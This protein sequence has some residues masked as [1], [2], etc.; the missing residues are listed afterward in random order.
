ML[1]TEAGAYALPGDIPVEAAGIAAIVP[2]TVASA[3]EQ[4]ERYGRNAP[5]PLIDKDF[6]Y[7]L[8]LAGEE[9]G[10]AVLR[11]EGLATIAEVYLDERLILTS[12][13]MFESHDMPVELT[14][15]EVV[16]ICFRALKP[17]LERRGSRA[18]WR[19]R[20]VDNQ[21]LRMVRTTLLGFM[22]GWNPPVQA[23]GPWRP[24]SLIRPGKMRIFGLSI[25][26]GLAD[27]VG[28]LNVSFAGEGP[29]G[30]MHLVCDGRQTPFVFGDG[31]Y[32]AELT[33]PDI[34]PW[35]PHT[36]GEPA[37]YDIC[38]SINGLIL[39]LTRTGFRTVTLDRGADGGDFAL[40][41]N[42]ERIF[43]RGSVWTSADIVSL[44]GG[45]QSY[46][47]WLRLAKEAGMNM[48]RIPGITVYENPEFFALC[49]ELGLMVWQDL[50]FANFDYPATDPDFLVHAAI[51][52]EQFLD[53]TQ[54]SPSL[55]I[56]CGGSELWQQ[57]AMFGLPERI[58]KDPFCEEFLGRLVT[59]HRPD[60]PFVANSPSGGA[61][62]FYPNAGVAHYYGVGAYRQPLD[63]ARRAGIRFAAECLAFSN[64]SVG[65]ELAGGKA[66]IPRDTG[67]DWDF[68]DIRDHYLG[69]LYDVDPQSLRN[70]DFERYL[71]FS[72][73]VT[74]EVMEA[75]FAEWRRQGS[76]CN[77]ALTF[78]L[79]DVMPGPGWGVIASDGRPKPA[80]HALKRAFRPV[81][82]LFADEATNGLDIHMI[83]ELAS[84]RPVV[85]DVVCLRNG[86]IPVVS[87]KRE[88][89]LAGRGGE[90][91]ACT[92]L[93]GAF[94][95]TN[96]AYRFGPP[97]HDV[98]IARLI[99][100]ETGEVLAE[101]F[102]FPLG[103]AE[104]MHD[105]QI[106]VEL[107][108]DEDGFGLNIST[109]MFAQ[110]VSIDTQAYQPSDNG[111]HLGPGIMKRVRLTR[112]PE[113]QQTSPTGTIR[114]L[115][116]RRFSRF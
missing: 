42:G 84:D 21:G 86:K 93:F 70:D 85:L 73:A 97:A 28:L 62:P 19:P 31:R 71:A 49:D 60:L 13:S 55:A 20:L 59:D 15:R 54:A 24:I 10:P 65:E 96:H 3:L 40:I 17:R 50:M 35:W 109:D 113:A 100:A 98:T 68:E 44:P 6:W 2:G 52:V 26:A 45:R 107:F 64:L 92:D 111:F 27:G 29:A 39:P 115:G 94:F 56:I 103:R 36:H 37:L 4:A 63:D 57:G 30:D 12:E 106:S 69:E 90:A 91:I 116:S 11:L 53:N 47:P 38:M 22:R 33:L 108:E 32:S 79:Q 25:S 75:G 76:C 102:H 105:A 104:A 14:G 46:A 80:W 67:A 83:N 95:D 89:T 8:S 88:L 48:I 87:G 34:R 16:S 61:L 58:W 81:Q 23:V 66:G 77:G 82:V 74:G 110:S 78:T 1:A 7:R 114:S 112:L 51:E 5:E 43:C 101:A 99:N 41:V 9:P 18:R 72:R